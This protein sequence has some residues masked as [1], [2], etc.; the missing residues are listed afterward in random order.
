[1]DR[2]YLAIICASTVVLVGA[3]IAVSPSMK[4]DADRPKAVLRLVQPPSH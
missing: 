3:I 2:F 4:S 1:M